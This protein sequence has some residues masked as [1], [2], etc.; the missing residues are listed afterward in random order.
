MNADPV[1]V[2]GWIIRAARKGAG[3]MTMK[4]IVTL[5]RGGVKAATLNTR[6]CCLKNA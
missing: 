3:R 5:G 4:F 6:A 1:D 2:A